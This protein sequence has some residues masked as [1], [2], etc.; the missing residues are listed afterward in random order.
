MERTKLPFFLSNG[1]DPYTAEVV[2]KGYLCEPCADAWLEELGRIIKTLP[3]APPQ[4]CDAC[5]KLEEFRVWLPSGKFC[6]A[7]ADAR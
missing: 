2:V 5:G 4:P 7:C 1:C 3:K 6:R